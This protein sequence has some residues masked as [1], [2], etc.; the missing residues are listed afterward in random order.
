MK[1]MEKE[2]LA[3]E[4]IEDIRKEYS[5]EENGKVRNFFHSLFDI[6][7]DMMTYEEIDKMMKDNTVIHGSNMWILVLAILIASIGLNMNSTAV[8]IGAMLISP[9]MSGIMSMGYSIAVR[10]LSLLKRSVVRFGTQVAISLLTSTLYFIISP[11]NEPTSEMIARINPTIWDVLIALFGGV[12]GIIGNTRNK[13]GN[14]IPGVAI[15]TALMPPLCTAG[16]GIAT[17]QLKFFAGAFYLFLI[18]TLFIALSTAFVTLILGVPYHKNLSSEQQKKINRIIV[19]ITIVT[20]VPSIFIGSLTVYQTVIDKNVSDYL[21]NEFAFSDTQVVQSKTDK[22]KKSITVSLVGKPVSDETIKSLKNKMKDYNL[23]EYALHVTQNSYVNP[24]KDDKSV[25]AASIATYESAIN[26]LEKQLEEKDEEL[27]KIRKLAEEY[28]ENT[29]NDVDC[30]KLTSDAQ[31][32]FPQLEKCSCGIMSDSEGEYILLTAEVKSKNKI[33]S[34]EKDSIENWLK[35][36]SG[37]D[38]ATVQINITK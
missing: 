7:D 37:M 8:I 17:L 13:K 12:A 22:Q 29:K 34:A 5:Y 23:E 35:T 15:A 9:L 30:K 16:Y 24:D 3:E 19:V 25:N 2:N 21:T 26:E 6:H 38:R 20:I 10:D 11:L 4:I 33:S 1:K 36:A 28:K 18:N 32:I 31:L 27:E 14:V